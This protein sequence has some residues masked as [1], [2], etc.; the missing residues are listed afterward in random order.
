MAW[1]DHLLSIVLERQ[2]DEL[3]VAAGHEPRMFSQG[4]A[5]R[6][7]IPKM[8]ERDVRE[9]LGELLSMD[10]Q[11]QASRE[12]R[13]TFD[14]ASGKSG[15]FHVVVT[16][17]PE[18]GATFVKADANAKPVPAPE[19]AA[20]VRPVE[21]PPVAVA[22]PNGP[23]PDRQAL[24]ALLTEAARFRASDLHLADGEAPRARVDGR[25][26]LLEQ[27]ASTDVVTLLGLGLDDRAR[28]ER[29]GSVDIG[30]DVPGVGRVRVH[31]YAAFNGVAA[32]IRLLPPTAPSLAELG[33]PLPLDDLAMMPHGLVLLCGPAGS[34]KSTT[35]AA[36][37]QE[38]LRR[39]S[40]VLVTLEDPIEYGL[41]A[42]EGSLLR[43][44][45]VGRDVGTF[46]S[47]LRDALREDPD[48]LLVGEMRDQ[49]TIAL[50]LTAAETGHLVLASMHSRS[51]SSAIQRIFD[52]TAP[53]RQQQIKTQLADSLRAVVLQRLVP[54]SGHEGRVPVCEILR[55]TAAVASTI[56]EGRT[57]QLA[58]IIQSGRREG[59]LS[60]ERCLADRVRAGDISLEGAR[61]AANDV[62]TL[63]LYMN[64]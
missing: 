14:Y 17:E 35:L 19:A 15:R 16:V 27:R 62:S 9:L 34:G 41:Q 37:A 63:T 54:R 12:G 48:V 55:G 10:R 51:A 33:M 60:L 52:S 36:L 23:E 2:A 7:S 13:A 6:L 47:G 4:Q 25:L 64:D 28:L 42:T 24:A 30:T 57:A 59:M 20:P 56:R 29:N 44:R 11:A 58:S 49:E 5:R 39:R 40:I 32:A 22:S 61:A 26:R 21:G 43:R 31:V 38:A 8:S 50:A 46:A 45:Q 18:L 1:I 3:R 53:E